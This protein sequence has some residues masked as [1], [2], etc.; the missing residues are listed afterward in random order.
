MDQYFPQGSI[1]KSTLGTTT[2]LV[3]WW[4][5][6]H[7]MLIIIAVTSNNNS[8]SSNSSTSSSTLIKCLRVSIFRTTICSSRTCAWYLT[9][10]SLRSKTQH[11]CLLLKLT[12]MK[13]TKLIILNKWHRLQH[14]KINQW[15]TIISSHTHKRT[16]WIILH[17]FLQ[18]IVTW[19]VVVEVMEALD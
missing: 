1:T 18:N 10:K 7:H 17:P 4:L 9:L 15:F 13:S 3:W 19:V 16:Q 8:I 12:T 2:T 6:L 14:I 11:W 5:I